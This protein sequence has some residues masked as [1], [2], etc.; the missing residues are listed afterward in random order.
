M[1]DLDPAAHSV[2]RLLDG[3][4]DDQLA[5]PTPCADSSLATLLD[6]VMGLSL[7]F[8]W[9]ARKTTA[10][11]G[12]SNG[13]GPGQATAQHLDPDWRTLL[14]RRLSDLAH[15]WRSPTA[16]EGIAEAGGV[17]MP[18]EIMGTVASTSWSCTAGTLPARPASPTRATRP[19]RRPSWPSPVRPR[20]RSKRRVA[21][22][23]SGRWSRSPRTHLRSIGRSVSPAATQGGRRASPAAAGTR[24]R[25][26]PVR[27]RP[28]SPY[29][30]RPPPTLS[31]PSRRRLLHFALARLEELLDPVGRHPYPPGLAADPATAPRRDASHRQ[32]DSSAGRLVRPRRTGCARG[33]VSL[34][35]PVLIVGAAQV[36]A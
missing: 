28:L 1:L 6:H 34:R 11:E 20:G 32:C 33:A 7:A 12:G 27:P 17:Q 23:C 25:H 30:V 9:A 31:T 16:W 26:A 19:A 10:A 14:P 24:R 2:T 5:G 35:T 22:G 4:T 18:A 15:A 8:T 36:F 21:K 3:V 13:A 29:S